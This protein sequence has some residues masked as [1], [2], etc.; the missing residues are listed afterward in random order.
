MPPAPVDVVDDRTLTDW[1]HARHVQRE[2]TVHRDTT[3]AHDVVTV[4]YDIELRVSCPDDENLDPASPTVL[5]TFEKLRTLA[6]QALPA[7]AA[8]GIRIGAFEPLLHLRHATGWKPEVR[9]L[10]E[11]RHAGHDYFAPLD[12]DEERQR[13][14]IEHTLHELGVDAR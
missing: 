9:L 13:E 11:I 2:T 4:G 10:I 14:Q 12:A 1:V 8:S 3:R 6:R 7:A 5:A